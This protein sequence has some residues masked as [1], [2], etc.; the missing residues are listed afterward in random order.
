TYG[1][2]VGDKVLHFLASHMEGVAREG[3]VCCR[4]GDEEFVI[5]LP[6]TAAEEA[7]QVAEQLRE[8]LATT[9]RP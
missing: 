2:A 7:A 6:N 5:L 1:H 9:E 8:I 3:D 4:Y